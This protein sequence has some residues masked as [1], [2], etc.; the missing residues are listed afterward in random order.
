[1]PK[2]VARIRDGE[3]L[4]IRINSALSE[5]SSS[6]AGLCEAGHRAFSTTSSVPMSC[7]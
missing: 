5:I 6:V 3:V 2:F 7:L 4:K 1:V